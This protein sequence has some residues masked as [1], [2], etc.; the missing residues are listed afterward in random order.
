MAATS[1]YFFKCVACGKTIDGFGQWFSGGSKCPECGNGR[2]ETFYCDYSNLKSLICGKASETNTVWRY[3]DCLPLEN[4]NNIV[5]CGEGDISAE[6]WTFLEKYAS[7]LNI[8]CKVWVYRNDENR[9]TGT[10]KDAGASL[11]AS[12]LKEHGIKNYVVA[13][14]GNVANSF[15]CYM[16]KAGITLYAFVPGNALAMNSAGV[17]Y[18]GQRVFRVLGDYAKAKIIAKEFAGK[19]GFHITGGNTDP[20]RVEAKRTMVF[21]WLRNMP[22]FPTVYLQSLSGGTGPVAIEKAV[23]EA[24]NLGLSCRLPRFLMVQPDGCAPMAQAWAKA[25]SRSFPDGWLNDYPVYDNPATKIPTLA[26]GNPAT[27]PIIGDLT[28]RSG[29]DIFSFDESKCEDVAR[30][31]AFETQAGTGPA[32]SV[33]LGGFF[34]ALNNGLIRNGDVVMINIGEG[35]NRAPEFLKSLTYTEQKVS[36]TDECALIDREKLQRD[37][38]DKISLL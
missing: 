27:Y 25:K 6:R 12:V 9:A 26:T 3:F 15:A 23:R 36:H 14:T 30:A 18:Y 1:K 22:E 2:I 24:E 16:S 33:V 31:I 29:G 11:A 37:L 21:E 28:Y 13:S 20:L 5:S 35:L 19:Y 34:K 7:S 17:S 32:S 8:T 4:K 10:F 38:W